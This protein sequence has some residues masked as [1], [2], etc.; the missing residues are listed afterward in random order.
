MWIRKNSK[1]LLEHLKSPTFNHVKSINLSL[2][3]FPHFIEPYNVPHQKKT[4]D[5]PVL[6]ETPS[7]S[8]W[9]IPVTVDTNICY[10]HIL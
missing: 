3:I 6:S 2:L 10:Q 8:T 9:S 1:E 7:F 4:P 5:V